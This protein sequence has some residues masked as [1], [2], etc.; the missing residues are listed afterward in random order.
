MSMS[1]DLS[2][3]PQLSDLDTHHQNSSTTA[4]TRAYNIR[5]K[6]FYKEANILFNMFRPKVAIIVQSAGKPLEGYISHGEQE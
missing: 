1:S 5:S 4:S 2:L 6:G 3:A